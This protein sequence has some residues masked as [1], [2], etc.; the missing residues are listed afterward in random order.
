MEES[1]HVLLQ[2]TDLNLPKQTG[3][4]PIFLRVTL[5]WST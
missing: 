2:K 5:V 4:L 3:G 1:F